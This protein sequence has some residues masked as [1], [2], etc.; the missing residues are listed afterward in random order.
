MSEWQGPGAPFTVLCDDDETNGP[1]LPAAARAL[2]GD[3][4]LRTPR[5]RPYVYAN[6]VVSHDGRASFGLPGASGGGEVS[7]YNRHD[8]W[9]MG[10]LRARADAVL[11]G[12]NTLRTEPDHCW[13]AEYIFPPDAAAFAALRQ[14]EG[15]AESPLHV[16][17]SRDGNMPD[18]AVFRR[19][20]IDVMIA[21]T[22]AGVARARECLGRYPQVGY[23]TLGQDSV[24]LAALLRLLWRDHGVRTLLCEGGPTLY[25]AM[26]EARQV[27]DEFLTL[28]PILI[29]NTPGGSVRPSLV[30]GV[31]FAPSAPPTTHLL[32][33]RRVGSHLFLRSRYGEALPDP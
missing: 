22:A 13:T 14:A 3:W 29:G 31:A 23:L 19:P 12:D 25:G 21:S 7:R 15:R 17:V 8:K 28:S 1:S 27:D 33:V 11:V 9:L 32:S 24:D 2:Y 10:L 30:E 6:F 4:R 26:V 20:N 16:F 18:S 5:E